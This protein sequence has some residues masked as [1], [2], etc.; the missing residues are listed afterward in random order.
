MAL[1]DETLK[2]FD[3]LRATA[4]R[5]AIQQIGTQ[6]IEV[7]ERLGFELPAPAGDFKVRVPPKLRKRVTT[8]V[9]PGSDSFLVLKAVQMNPN[10][11]GSEIRDILSASNSPVNERTMRTALRRLRVRGF[12]EQN[13]D[14][15]WVAVRGK[16]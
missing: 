9:R 7:L 13:A 4:R 12:I 11:R 15:A 8:K 14:G 10:K 3:V 1:D 2:A 16:E 5:E 6:I